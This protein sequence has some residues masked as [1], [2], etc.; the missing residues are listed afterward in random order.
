MK[1]EDLIVSALGIIGL[2]IVVPIVIRGTLI[3]VSLVGSCVEQGRNTM[4][5]HKEM[6]KGIKEGKIVKI[7]GEYYNVVQT[8]EEE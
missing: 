8:I 6:K 7:N 2:I 3:G 5:F 1:N 4:K